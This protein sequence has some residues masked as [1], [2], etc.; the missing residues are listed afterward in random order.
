MQQGQSHQLFLMIQSPSLGS[1]TLKTGE[2]CQAPKAAVIIGHYSFLVL[3][4]KQSHKIPMLT[5]N[6]KETK[7]YVQFF[8]RVLNLV[9]F[10][11]FNLI[12]REE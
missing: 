4:Q 5:P 8:V 10:V 3:S 9:V 11:D 2:N 1:T 12:D 6:W 7:F